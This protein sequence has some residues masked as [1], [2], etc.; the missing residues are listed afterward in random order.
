M[1]EIIEKEINFMLG[2]MIDCSRN[3]VMNLK[4][5]KRFVDIIKLM[6]YDTL[7][8][9]TEDT[10]EVDGHPLF[11]CMRGKYTKNE[12]KE[13]DS[14]CVENGIELIPC[15]QT[16]AHLNCMFR[17]NEYAD[18][19]DCDDIL[20]SE[21]EKTYKLIESMFST[22]S[23]C[24]TSKKIHIGMDEAYRV[25]MGKYRTIHGECDR[26]DIINRH[27]HRVC[28]LT[29]KYGL[30]PMI[31]SDMFCKLALDS[32]NY[33][34][35]EGAEAIK[36][37]SD[38]P[39]NI[40]LVYWDYYSK[41]YDHYV[42]MINT[43]KLFGRKV[44]FAGGAWTW[45]GIA[46]ENKFSIETTDV[47][48]KA[49]KDCNV[50]D[51]FFTVWGDDG[52]ECTP[53]TILPALM[54]GAEAIRGNNDI[55]SIKEKFKQIVGCDFDS[56]ML[57]DELNHPGGKHENE[58]QT[59][60]YI[61]YNDLFTGIKD[62][63]CSESDALFYKDLAERIHNADKSGYEDM[64]DV[65]ECLARLVAIKVD[66]GVRTRKA[67]QAADKEALKKI[68]EDYDILLE[69]TEVFH[70][71]YQK[72]WF[73]LNKPHGFDIQDVR[74]GGLIQRIKSCRNRLLDYVNGSVLEIAELEEEMP[75]GTTG[76]FWR[77]VVS[78]NT[79]SHGY[80]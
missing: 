8:L 59:C 20:L 30:E 45:S 61:L 6:G 52:G 19:N 4:S 50:D 66:L 74:L 7:M 63:L 67:Y 10:Y 11:G 13:I 38:L 68:I 24:F 5:L 41:D 70:K 14:Y 75:H 18:I 76:P 39:E 9:Y 21:D 54:Y 73:K 32:D 49:C 37:K 29:D 35:T 31:W 78:P 48:L 65:Y 2:V 27:L 43:N 80:I 25:G 17:W 77:N 47:A 26:F 58:N 51:L 34:E 12:I 1:F 44:Y 40:S 57:L 53:F 42:K 56:F 55:D 62:Y 15:I 46:P 71:S 23:Q 16:L 64:F 79:I 36:E 3:A 33:Y 69:R 28:D 72:L 22:I 60:K